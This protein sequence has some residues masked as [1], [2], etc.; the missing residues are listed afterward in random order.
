MWTFEPASSV[1]S[2]RAQ[3]FGAGWVECRFTRVTGRLQILQREPPLAVCEG[4]I[5]ATH[6]EPG[7]PR[8]NSELRIP[9]FL[10]V[11]RNPLIPFQARITSLGQSTPLVADAMVRIRGARRRFDLAAAWS[12]ATTGSGLGE[13]DAARPRSIELQATARVERR[14]LL[15][16][17]DT[18]APQDGPCGMVEI[19]FH[20]DAI[21]DD[22]GVAGPG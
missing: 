14:A 20:A 22:P 10:D 2:V 12:I 1:L 19:E 21:R 5:D 16:A 11:E 17:T 6:F 8:L 7:A 18:E 13:G 3:R 9:D 15:G 4:E